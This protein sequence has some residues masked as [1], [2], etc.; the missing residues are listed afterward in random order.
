M[1]D[2]AVFYRE[3]G[4]AAFRGRRRWLFLSADWRHEVKQARDFL[5][6][7]RSEGE[8]RTPEERANTQIVRSAWALGPR[9]VGL[10]RASSEDN[11]L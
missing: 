5:G 9:M 11:K 8:L 4:L 1:Q 10:S 6:Y 7:F 2:F 3:R